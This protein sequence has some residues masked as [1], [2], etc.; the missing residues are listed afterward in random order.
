MAGPGHHVRRREWP[1]LTVRVYDHSA[2]AVRSAGPDAPC[3][4][5]PRPFRVLAYAV[6]NPVSRRTVCNVVLFPAALLSH[7][8]FAK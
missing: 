4:A 5:V 6:S 3:R 8:R 1:A 7:G 2:R